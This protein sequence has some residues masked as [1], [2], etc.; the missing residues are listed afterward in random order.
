MSTVEGTVPK[1]LVIVESPAK[2]R[3][4][5]KFLGRDYVVEASYGHVRDLPRGAAGAPEASRGQPWARTGVDPD[6][7][8]KTLYVVPADKKERIRTLKSLLKDADELY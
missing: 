6:N 1:S 2:A 5:S 8:F 3:T 4:I 7:A